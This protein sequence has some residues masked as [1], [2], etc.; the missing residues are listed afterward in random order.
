[1]CRKEN[2]ESH[3]DDGV[4]GMERRQALAVLIIRGNTIPYS[5]G[6]VL[7]RRILRGCVVCP[8][9]RNIA[10]LSSL[11]PACASPD[12]T[13]ELCQT[14]ITRWSVW[15]D[16]GEGHAREARPSTELTVEMPTNKGNVSNPRGEISR[17]AER[18]RPA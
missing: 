18:E 15:S 1:M 4:G 9:L 5:R 13:G 16:G 7:K 14:G 12:D 2:G 17:W 8:L 11:F 3:P 6:L 10:L